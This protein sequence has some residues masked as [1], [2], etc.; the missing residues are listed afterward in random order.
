MQDKLGLPFPQI[1]YSNLKT[2]PQTLPY[3]GHISKSQKV[4][5]IKIT[6][7]RQPLRENPNACGPE[8]L[9]LS[10][11]WAMCLFLLF[12]VSVNAVSGQ[13]APA[14]S[15]Y[16]DIRELSDLLW[17]S[18]SA[19][20]LAAVL[21]NWVIS[22]TLSCKDHILCSGYSEGPHLKQVSKSN[23]VLLIT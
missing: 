22:V 10:L 11:Q 4:S 1:Y 20:D 5:V 6:C 23:Q 3:R 14:S 17:I 8:W 12:Q 21:H 19:W 2:S 18:Q 7:I 16:S 9:G 13:Q 15:G